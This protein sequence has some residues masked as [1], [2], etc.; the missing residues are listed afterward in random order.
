MAVGGLDE[1]FLDEVSSAP[2][3]EKRI[4]TADSRAFKKINSEITDT[5]TSRRRLEYT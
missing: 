5:I 2:K 4:R 1:Y 3:I